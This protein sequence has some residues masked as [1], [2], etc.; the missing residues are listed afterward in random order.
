V[1]SAYSLHEQD[2]DWGQPG[3]LVRVVLDDAARERLVGNV[4]GH[5]LGGVTCSAPSNTGTTWTRTSA[6]RSRPASAPSRVSPA[7][8]KPDDRIT[9]HSVIMLIPDPRP[10]GAASPRRRAR[11][12]T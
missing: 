2:D 4:V 3:T 1:R 11:S 12:T 5:L 6:T 8:P 7:C 10:G 9:A